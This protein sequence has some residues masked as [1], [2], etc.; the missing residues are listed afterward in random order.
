MYQ[1]D[2]VGRLAPSSLDISRAA[3]RRHTHLA[4]L[5]TAPGT[6]SSELHGRSAPVRWARVVVGRAQ[7][8]AR[9]TRSVRA[10]E[11]PW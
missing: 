5:H 3:A 9:G 4:A 1:L 8:L 2:P 7:A 10:T 11:V 6:S